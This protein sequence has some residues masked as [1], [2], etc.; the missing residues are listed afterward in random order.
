MQPQSKLF[1]TLPFDKLS[2]FDKVLL[3]GGIVLGLALDGGE[4]HTSKKQNK[5]QLFSPQNSAE[6]VRKSSRPNFATKSIVST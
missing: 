3:R 4:R 6:K 1:A 2:R 5:I